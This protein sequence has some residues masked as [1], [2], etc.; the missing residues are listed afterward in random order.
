MTDVIGW[1]NYINH[2][3][4]CNRANCFTL[5]VVVSQRTYNGLNEPIILISVVWMFRY[6]KQICLTLSV[7][8]SQ[9]TY[10]GLN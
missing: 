5:S 3:A 6:R 7:V 9:R 2:R 1:T 4:L 10:N 8:V